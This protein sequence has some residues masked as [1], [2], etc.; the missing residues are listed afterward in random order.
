MQYVAA[1]AE[2]YRQSAKTTVDTV[3]VVAHID[4]HSC[5][6]IAEG[7]DAGHSATRASLCQPAPID[8]QG[9]S[10]GI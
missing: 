8:H 9:N 6:F 3:S 1:T 7:V 2:Y 5:D 4:L 10:N